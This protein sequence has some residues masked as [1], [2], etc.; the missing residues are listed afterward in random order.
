MRN[1]FVAGY[2][3]PVVLQATD[4]FETKSEE[5]IILELLYLC[6]QSY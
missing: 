1:G 5:L 4:K 6:R 3:N 2:S